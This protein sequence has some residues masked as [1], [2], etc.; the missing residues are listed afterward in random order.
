MAG[1]ERHGTAER[2]LRLDVLHTV[3]DAP[4]VRHHVVQREQ[5]GLAER[6]FDAL[7]LLAEALRDRSLVGGT[8]ARAHGG[9]HRGGGEREAHCGHR[10][11]GAMLPRR[12]RQAVGASGPPRFH[13]VAIEEPAKVLRQVACGVVAARRVLLQAFER[14]RL[15]VGRHRRH[16]PPQRH[17]IFVQ[18]LQQ[19]LDRA[20]P[21]ER[22][23]P[24]DELVQHGPQPVDVRAPVEGV[25][26][27]ARLLGR[28]VGRRPQ[29]QTGVRQ[30]FGGGLAG[31]AEVQDIGMQLA[32]AALDHDVPRLEVAMHEPGPVGGVHPIRD[33]RHQADLLV[34]GEGRA[35][36]LQRLPLDVLHGDVGTT[37]RFPHFVDAADVRM[38]HSRLEAGLAHQPL[39][40]GRVVLVKELEGDRAAENGIEGSKDRAHPAFAQKDGGVVPG[41]HLERFGCAGV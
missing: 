37:G 21:L 26:V 20:L 36:S 7:D 24:R 2:H 18:D 34:Q 25:N 28:H 39:D 40:E 11:D 33:R 16:E 27:A 3:S 4:S 14:D 6:A 22:R 12:A 15:D 8:P 5:V 9:A 38:V 31:Q 35:S 30:P 41:G 29:G 1:A 13:G 32:V 17:R 19:D 23:P 10:Q